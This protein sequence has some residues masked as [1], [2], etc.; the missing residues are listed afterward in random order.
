MAEDPAK[1]PLGVFSGIIWWLCQDLKAV[2]GSSEQ[3]QMS[4]ENPCWSWAVAPEER[5]RQAGRRQKV[6]G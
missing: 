4:G 2:A 6:C 3:P 1:Y 5:E